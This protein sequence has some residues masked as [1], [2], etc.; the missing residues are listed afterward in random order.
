MYN[1]EPSGCNL[2]ILL[3]C[4]GFPQGS[5]LGGGVR[6]RP[7]KKITITKNKEVRIPNNADF[8]FIC[9]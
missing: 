2:P 6:L 5:R 4:E 9:N 7:Y 8:L 3:G 1:H